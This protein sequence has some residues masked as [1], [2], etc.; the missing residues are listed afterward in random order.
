MDPRNTIGAMGATGAAGPPRSLQAPSGRWG[1]K[2]I[3]GLLALCAAISVLTT[4]GIVISLLT[5]TIAFFGE[6]AV[7]DFLFGT[8]WAPTFT[9]SSFGV[10]PLVVGTLSTSLWGM[11]VAVPVG[12][13]SAVFLS[14][15]ASPRVR[16]V[17][18]PVIEVLAGIPTVA[19]G[20]FALLWLSPT[21][22]DLA[23]FMVNIAPFSAGIAGIAIGLMI[24][25]IIASISDDAMR[26]V[27]AGLREAA[28]GLGATKMKVAVRVVFPAAI[29]GVVASI[30]LAASR[31]V[32]ETMVVLL[33]AGASPR[34]T[35]DPGASVQTMTA[36][37]GTTATGDIAPGTVK[38]DTIFAV[39]TLLFVMTLLMNVLAI[40]LVR[41]YRE[42]YE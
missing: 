7:G 21:L 15:Y 12:L 30:V 5:P 25:P 42:V 6:V 32:G 41:K 40:R 4:T 36:F 29:S 19:I 28:Y 1:E 37:I 38:Y 33:V 34:L 27:P 22:Q 24:V 23:P 3:K 2:A 14:E 10:L 26:A 39:G 18:K 8:D 20:V 11:V 17:V 16:K 35:F 13:L 9:P 31:A